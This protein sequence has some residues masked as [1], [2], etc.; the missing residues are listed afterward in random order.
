MALTL[1]LLLLSLSG[2]RTEQ[3]AVKTQAV[4]HRQYPLPEA[5][6]C[7]DRFPVKAD[8]V[9][10][11]PVIKRDTLLLPGAVIYADCDSAW[12]AANTGQSPGAPSALPGKLQRA[13]PGFEDH[14]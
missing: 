2:C 14:P 1:S 5:R 10:G 4:I 3:W 6:N 9:A 13:V 12:K 11:V 7:A 8:T